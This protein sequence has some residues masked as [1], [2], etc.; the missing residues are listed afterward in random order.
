MKS[1]DPSNWKYNKGDERRLPLL[2][3]LVTRMRTSYAVQAA[4]K[5]AA[6]EP[7]QEPVHRDE[8][9]RD[10]QTPICRHCRLFHGTS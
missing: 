2:R 7:E 6:G 8:K 1:S 10:D 5:A 9:P 4:Q 3:P